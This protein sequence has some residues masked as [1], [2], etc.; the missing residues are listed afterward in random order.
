[1]NELLA[2]GDAARGVTTAAYNLPNDE[3]VVA[4]HG[5]KRVMLKNVQEAKFRKVLEPIAA[6]VL[7]P[8]DRARVAFDPFFTHILMHE[9]VHGLGPH[10]IRAGGRDTTVRAALGDLSSAIEEAKADVGGLF[11]LDKLLREGKLDRRM[12]AT[13]YPTFVASAIRS[14]RFGANEAHGRGM[15][16]QLGWFLDHGAIRAGKDGT[17]SVDAAR[18]REAV[19]GLTREIMTLQARGDRAAAQALLDRYAT[20]R[21]EVE[22]AVARLAAVPVD[23][24]PRF[25]TADALAP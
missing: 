8:S 16:L 17:L 1:V 14:I 21:P 4:A 11:A 25:T 13:L 12:E 19:T 15:A 22:R 9:L 2:T 20:P 24:A 6:V 7:S 23:I 5:S 10:Q 18:M 3:A